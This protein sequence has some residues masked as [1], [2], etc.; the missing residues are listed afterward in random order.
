M[1]TIQVRIDDDLKEQATFVF[2][3]LGIDLSTAIRMF[4]TKSV[5]VRGIPFSLNDD[6]NG[7]GRIIELLEKISIQ[8][9]M[10]GKGELTLDD[11]NKEISDARKERR[12]RKRNNWKA[13]MR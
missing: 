13:F 4:L 12:E 2:E 9:N 8:S 1:A 5:S 10:N 7:R 11:I 6:D 3:N